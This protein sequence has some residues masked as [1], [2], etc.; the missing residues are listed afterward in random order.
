MRQKMRKSLVV[1][2][3]ISLLLVSFI[4]G[5]GSNSQ[6]SSDADGSKQPPVAGG[7]LKV[8]YTSEPPTLDMHVTNTNVVR[9]VGR[10]VFEGLFTYNGNYEVT[11]M[12]A[13]SY[14]I[15]DDKKTVTIAL[16][17]GVLFHNG[18]EM[19]A[20]DVV[21]SMEKWQKQNKS[22]ASVL[23][24][25]TWEI[26]DDYTVILHVETPTIYIMDTLADTSQAASIY[27]K[28]VV[29]G[30]DATGIKA[31]IGT[32]PFKV[33][34]WRAG[35]YLHLVKFDDY[36]A[37]SLPASGLAGKKEALVDDLY[38][39]FVG[40]ESTR[41]NGITS[42]EYDYS[43]E[44]P[45]DS[46]TQ[47]QSN[48]DLVTDI[49]PFGFQTLVFNKKQG[50]FTDVKM[51]QAV[52]LALDSD[53]LLTLAFT[54]KQ[55]YELEPAYMRPGQKNWYTD[56]GK[57]NYNQRNLEK[58]KELLKEAGYNGEEIVI[59]TSSDYKYHYNS[60]IVA[61]ECLEKIGM[62]VTLD[63][64]DWAS[65]LQRRADPS[66][67]NIFFT[68]FTTVATPL[69]Y[70]F[71]DSKA[72]YPGWTNNP[73]IDQFLSAIRQSSTQE[74]ATAKFQELQALIWTD[75]PVINVGMTNRISGYSKK[76]QGYTEF[77][78]PIFWNTTVS[79]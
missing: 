56:A 71:L 72:N 19:K 6:T 54:D 48:P 39:Y 69:S 14:Q 10:P 15:S 52:N 22:A 21:A 61:K 27:P 73:Q 62:K 74:E 49:W 63:V 12:L 33:D 28:E 60:A 5:C 13:E 2:T 29:E 32:G 26:K 59:L 11:P 17:K 9:D 3:V 40:D 8:A 34:E 1:L 67:W 64:T 75:L 23:G 20:E 46:I 51:R 45:F 70:P 7:T 76:V 79:Q 44:L 65:L 47:L 30:A 24:N 50:V 4:S 66:K 18:K 78:G 41:L 31:F 35:Q 37:S 42:G 16:R 53:E 55:F 77:M 58:A 57:E 25:S 43:Y 38:I 68:S 36:Q